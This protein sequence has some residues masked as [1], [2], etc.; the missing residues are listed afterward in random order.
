MKIICHYSE[1]ALKGKNRSFFEK[2]LVKN[3]RKTLN[4]SFLKDVKRMSG[5]VLISL[6]KKG[7]N[8]IKEIENSL[9]NVFGIVHFSFAKLVPQ[10]IKE[11]E[12][13][14]VK[15]LKDKEFKT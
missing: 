9:K 3:I 2:T 15:E 12:K 6:N 14:A 4:K 7:E 5:R 11:I 10:D 13:E 8:N 1:I